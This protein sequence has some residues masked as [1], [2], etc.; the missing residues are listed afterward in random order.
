MVVV[1][2]RVLRGVKHERTLHYDYSIPPKLYSNNC[3]GPNDRSKMRRAWD[4][5]YYP[6]ASRPSSPWACPLLECENCLNLATPSS[7][8]L[9]R[10]DPN[11]PRPQETPHRPSA[12]VSY[13]IWLRLSALAFNWHSPTMPF[14]IQSW[15]AAPKLRTPK[16][17][18]NLRQSLDSSRCTST[19]RHSV[20][21][22][23]GW[24]QSLPEQETGIPCDLDV[25]SD[26][27]PLVKNFRAHPSSCCFHLRLFLAP[28]ANFSKTF[29]RQILTRNS[30][31]YAKWTR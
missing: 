22:F 7:A 13:R 19:V 5:G 8:H 12:E 1:G 17:L 9:L 15:Q 4:L 10:R 28:A 29:W 24:A 25:A 31:S 3:G 21:A 16:T 14:L 6:S 20:F 23:R 2:A 27:P 11:T 26:F 18:L 30:I